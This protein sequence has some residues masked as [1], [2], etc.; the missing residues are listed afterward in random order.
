[1]FHIG[2]E[3]EKAGVL[4]NKNEEK[5]LSKERERGRDGKVGPFKC[6]I[7]RVNQSVNTNIEKLR[8]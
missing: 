6:M 5:S 8:N 3:S 4:S 1:M 7:I 2:K